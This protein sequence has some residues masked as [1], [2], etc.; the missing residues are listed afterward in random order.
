MAEATPQTFVM[1]SKKAKVILEWDDNKWY[2]SD[3]E[4][5]IGNDVKGGNPETPVVDSGNTSAGVKSPEWD[6]SY[7]YMVNDIVAWKGA[8]YY[9]KQNQNQS[10]DPSSGTFWW[11]TIVDLS[12]VD[13]ITLEGKNLA[14]IT[15]LILNGTDISDFYLKKEIDNIILAY[16]NNVNAKKLSDWTLAEIKADYV[17][18]ITAV[19]SAANQFTIDYLK[20]STESGFDQSLVNIFNSYIVNDNINQI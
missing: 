1:T 20:D 3:V 12:Q 19:T 9:S 13:A 17:A 10:N 6:T 4:Y 7:K 8:F 18:K 2:I 16:F 14:E 15:R 5:I 11:G